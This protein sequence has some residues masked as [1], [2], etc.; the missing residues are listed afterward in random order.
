MCWTRLISFELVET[1]LIQKLNFLFK[2]G[3]VEHDY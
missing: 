1:K 3:I 2:K